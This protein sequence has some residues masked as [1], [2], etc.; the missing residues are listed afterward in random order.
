MAT[1]KPRYAAVIRKGGFDV[2]SPLVREQLREKGY[3][4]GDCV[5][6]E[7]YKSRNPKFNG[8]AHVFGQLLADNLDD[9]SGMDS[10]DVLKRLQVEANVG[11]DEMMLRGDFGMFWHR[12]PRSLSFDNMDEGEF[13]KTF[14]GLARHVAKKYWPTMTPEQIEQMA[15]MMPD[16]P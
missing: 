13:K 3:K 1:K 2:V 4:A 5:S 16:S 9:F 15:G 7:I 14:N 10:H 8:L 11:C 12:V 6:L